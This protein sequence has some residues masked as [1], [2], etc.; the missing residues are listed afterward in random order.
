MRDTDSSSG[1]EA[2]QNKVVIAHGAVFSAKAAAAAFPADQYFV[3]IRFKIP[4]VLLWQCMF[5]SFLG[6]SLLFCGSTTSMMHHRLL[7]TEGVRAP[8]AAGSKLSLRG[9]CERVARRS[10]VVTWVPD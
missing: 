7:R 4:S 9:P 10:I 1:Q 5:S 2:T 8:R 3:Q 6:A